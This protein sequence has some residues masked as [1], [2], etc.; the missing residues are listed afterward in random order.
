MLDLL[1]SIVAIFTTA[2]SAVAPEAPSTVSGRLERKPV[3]PF[4]MPT[5]MNRTVTDRNLK[6]RPYVIGFC[7]DSD[8][9]FDRF[10]P[11]LR[12]LT[13]KFSKEGLVVVAATGFHQNRMP[14]RSLGVTG[15]QSRHCF[16]TFNNDRL[17]TV[18][19]IRTLPTIVVVDRSGTV[20][21]VQKDPTERNRSRLMDAVTVAAR[22]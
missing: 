16:V 8:R 13:H 7:S 21:L 18:W 5:T 22:K 17:M 9:S 3:P 2:F 6:G 12:G 15:N 14:S 1:K 10:A 11:V 19:G 4:S 20:V